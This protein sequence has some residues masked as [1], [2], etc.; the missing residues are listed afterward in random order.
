MFRFGR[1]TLICGISFLAFA[2]FQR[3]ANSQE[4]AAAEKEG[5]DIRQMLDE[6]SRIKIRIDRGQQPVMAELKGEPIMRYTDPQR[7]F[8]DATLWVW[9]VDGRPAVFSKLERCHQKSNPHWQYCMSN[10]QDENVTVRWPT[11]V[12][13]KSRQPGIRFRSFDEETPIPKTASLRLVQLRT[14]LRKFRGKTIDREDHP[15]EMR[16]LPQPILRYSN[17]AIVDGAVFAFTSNGTNPDALVLI[18]ARQSETNQ[19]IWEYG[20]LG[21]SGDVVQFE[22]NGESVDRHDGAKSPGDFG[23]WLWLVLPTR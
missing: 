23:H 17:A 4:N 19:P 22:L 21:L 14:M 11:G 6:V 10:V 2:G 20:C 18:Q 16:P 7:E 3:P 8:P 1:R 5:F 15:E 13:W 9:T 12:V